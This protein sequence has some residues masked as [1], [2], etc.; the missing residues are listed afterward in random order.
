MI[1]TIMLLTYCLNADGSLSTTKSAS[2]TTKLSGPEAKTYALGQVDPHR[3]SLVTFRHV[4]PY[5][6]MRGIMHSLL[7]S[8]NS[9]TYAAFP[10][11]NLGKQ[12][13][14]VH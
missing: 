4:S 5:V 3:V 14:H 2:T 8:E 12:M 13:N 6:T 1:T 10:R 11:N 7:N 9:K